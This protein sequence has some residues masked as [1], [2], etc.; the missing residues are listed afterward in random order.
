MNSTWPGRIRWYSSATGSLTLSTSSPVVPDVVGRRQDRRARGGEVLVG[1]RGARAGARL[2]EHLVPGRA[3]SC[4]PAGVI[5]TRNS[6][7]FTSA[8]T[9]TFMA[10]PSPGAGGP[11]ARRRAKTKNPS[12]HAAYPLREVV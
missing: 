3:S 11:P 7:F 5:A 9:P 4:T 8:G 12:V 1:Q 10:P 6:L 2:D